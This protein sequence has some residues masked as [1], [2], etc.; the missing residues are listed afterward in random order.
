MRPCQNWANPLGT[1]L[2]LSASDVGTAVHGKEGRKPA[3]TFQQLCSGSGTWD[4]RG[5][6]PPGARIFSWSNTISVRRVIR[7]FNS[8]PGNKNATFSYILSPCQIR[9]HEADQ[10]SRPIDYDVCQLRKEVSDGGQLGPEMGNASINNNNGTPDA[11]LRRKAIVTDSWWLARMAL[12]W[13]STLSQI[14]SRDPLLL[15][16]YWQNADHGRSRTKTSNWEL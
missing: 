14:L 10:T 15:S 11:I 12:V 3:P 8:I 16:V 1:V 4:W 2:L 5:I 9:A 13:L 7:H 6:V